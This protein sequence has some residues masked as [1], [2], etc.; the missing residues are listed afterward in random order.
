MQLDRSINQTGKGK[1]ALIKLR[2]ITGDPRTPEELAAAILAH[3]ECV[4][5]GAR[6]SGSEFFLLRLKD[7]YAHPALMAYAT[8]AA[9]DDEEWANQV[10]AL[11]YKAKHNPGTKVPD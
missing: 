9:E 7:K 5:W 4:D 1:Y 8:A 3:P 2:E 10:L 11:A 6:H